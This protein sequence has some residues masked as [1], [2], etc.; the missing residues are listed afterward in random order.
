MHQT[1]ARSPHQPPA[2]APHRPRRPEPEPP[3]RDLLAKIVRG[4]LAVVFGGFGAGIL[5]FLLA[6]VLSLF[7]G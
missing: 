3:E 6:F 1:P 5:L 4:T 2:R 7:L